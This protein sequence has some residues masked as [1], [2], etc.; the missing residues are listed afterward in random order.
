[1]HG[2]LEKN[3]RTLVTWIIFENPF[4]EKLNTVKIFLYIQVS[5][6]NK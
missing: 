6:P 2:K 5:I 1:M 3:K 4:S